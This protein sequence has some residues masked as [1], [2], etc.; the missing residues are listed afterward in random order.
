MNALVK[1]DSSKLL[2]FPASWYPLCRSSELKRQQVIKRHASGLPLAVFRTK[3]GKVCAVHSEC[4]HM[5]ADLARGRVIGERLQ[6]PL[7]EWEY[8]PSGMCEHIPA[9][10]AVPGRAR[11]MSLVCKEQYGM[12]FGFLGGVPTFDYPLFEMSDHDLYS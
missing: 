7:H 12:V 4:V 1:N 2:S 10:A 6:C 3:G 8:S 5:G 11:Q 9:T